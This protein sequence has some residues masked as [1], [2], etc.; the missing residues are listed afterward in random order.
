MIRRPRLLGFVDPDGQAD[1]RPQSII[2]WYCP[3]ISSLVPVRP[4]LAG[5]PLLKPLPPVCLLGEGSHVP[6]GALQGGY[7]PL[8]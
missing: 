2:A 5:S 4:L 8:P 1:A 3:I 7:R 6:A